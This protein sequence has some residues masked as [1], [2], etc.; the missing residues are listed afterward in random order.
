MTD[1]QSLIKECAE[2]DIKLWADGGRL[3]VDAPQGAIDDSLKTRLGEHKDAL[4]AFLAGMQQ[5]SATKKAVLAHIENPDFIPLTSSQARIWALANI[6]KGSSVYNVPVVFQVEGDF[7]IF[8]LNKALTEIQNRHEVLRTVFE[9]VDGQPR[10][11]IKPPSHISVPIDDLW[12]SVATLDK[13]LV[14]QELMRTITNEVIKPFDFENGP[15]WRAR[16]FR[17][18]AQN[19][20]IAL[21]V[22]HIIFDGLSKVILLRELS[23]HYNALLR[24]QE[25]AQ[26]EPLQIQFADFAIWQQQVADK[27]AI[28]KQRQYWQQKLE[29]LKAPLMT[30]NFFPRPENKAPA[31]SLHFKFKATTSKLILQ[32]ASSTR[33]SPFVVLMATFAALLNRYTNQKD[34]VVCSPMASRENSALEKLIGYFN[35]IVPIR[36]KMD[37]RAGFSS[38]IKEVRV[39]ALEAYDN[40]QMPLQEIA[41]FDNLARIPLTRA[42][43]SYQESP[44]DSLKLGEAK[45]SAINVRKGAADFDLAIYLEQ[46]GDRIGGVMDYNAKIFKSQIMERFIGRFEEY[47]AF[48]CANPEHPINRTQRQGKKPRDVKRELDQH[49]QIDQAIVVSNY[50]SGELNAYL[51]LNEHDVPKLEDIK[52]YLKKKLPDY[53]V[54]AHLIPLDQFPLLEDGKIDHDKLPLPSVD[55]SY[56][57]KQYREPESTLEKSLADI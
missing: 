53:R 57:S 1:I 13:K 12:K 39:A 43:L 40:Q 51:I 9:E 4:I 46:T 49:P 24:T 33:S 50:D 2:K 26:L 28:E 45:T 42:M 14:H 37:T 34:I 55:R 29:G 44:E 5:P 41:E 15:L 32:M 22:H 17:M 56:L 35:N 47:A 36:F 21:T 52:A 38:L 23:E 8:L 18:L 31:T 54:P 25:P 11:V 6:D 3:R 20:I 10:Q 30:P 16:A 48:L 27:A 7:D 19:H